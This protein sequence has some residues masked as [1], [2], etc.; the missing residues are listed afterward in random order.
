MVW[1]LEHMSYKERVTAP[2]VFSLKIR[3]LR[4]NL[5]MEELEK[6]IRLPVPPLWWETTPQLQKGKF[7]LDIRNFFFSMRMI[8]YCHSYPERM[9]NLLLWEYAEQNWTT[10][11]VT[12]SK[13]PLLWAVAGPD[14][15]QQS[16]PTKIIFWFYGHLQGSVRNEIVK[17]LS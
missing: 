12:W 10:T 3:R 1:G 13:L 11:W 7:W 17:Y 2:S 14:N 8:K 5:L 15:T 6:A 4:R 16:L 9:W